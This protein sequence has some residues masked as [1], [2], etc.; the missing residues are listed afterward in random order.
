MITRFFL[1]ILC[2]VSIPIY[3]ADSVATGMTG[4]FEIK[5]LRFGG[6]FVR[7]T[8]ST[9][10]EDPG[11]CITNSRGKSPV[12]LVMEDTKS[13]KEIVSTLLT[14]KAAGKS[15]QFW[16]NGCKEDSGLE[17]PNGTFIYIE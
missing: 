17:Y 4:Y 16:I 5:R 8:A 9:Q 15:V 3:A 12:V 6:G 2:F 13:Y 14:A 7:V 1:T 11:D 10:F